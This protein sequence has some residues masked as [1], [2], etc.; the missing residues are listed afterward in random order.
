MYGSGKLPNLEQ[1]ISAVISEETRLKLEEIGGAGVSHGRS[2]LLAS[3]TTKPHGQMI[4]FG[5][6]T[7]FQC[8]KPGRMKASFSVTLS[9]S[10]H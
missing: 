6:W 8:G 3:E 2:A 7:C 10:T 9:L 1:A 5:E 4:N